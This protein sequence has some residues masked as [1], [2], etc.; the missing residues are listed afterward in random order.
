M[1]YGLGPIWLLILKTIYGF[2]IK[3][4]KKKKKNSFVSGLVHCYCFQFSE[5]VYSKNTVDFFFFENSNL[6]FLKTIGCA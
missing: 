4:K 5:I 6:V 1:S 2:F 3:K